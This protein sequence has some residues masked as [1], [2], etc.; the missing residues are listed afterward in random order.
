MKKVSDFVG[1]CRIFAKMWR[2]DAFGQRGC[3]KV[4]AKAHCTTMPQGLRAPRRFLRTTTPSVARSGDAARR[5]AC[6]TICGEGALC[7]IVHVFGF[8]APRRVS[9][10]QQE[11]P[12]HD[13][14]CKIVQ[15]FHFLEIFSFPKNLTPAA[16]Q[17]KSKPNTGTAMDFLPRWLLPS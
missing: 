16:V 4:A 9:A 11:C 7:K 1:C 3:A 8:S 15:R 17:H 2:S 14:V 5:S 12:L 6:A 10:R 13:E